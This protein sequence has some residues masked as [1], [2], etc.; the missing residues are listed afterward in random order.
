ML[1]GHFVA[2]THK[3]IH[4]KDRFFNAAINKTLNVPEGSSIKTFANTQSEDVIC[5]IRTRSPFNTFAHAEY[6]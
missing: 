6:M 1:M 2:A 4:G 3:S 5:E